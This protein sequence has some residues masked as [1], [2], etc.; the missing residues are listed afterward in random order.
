MHLNNQ[1]GL[2]KDASFD[3]GTPRSP[4]N[5]CWQDA[6][7]SPASRS[8]Q[9]ARFHM[10]AA[11]DPSGGSYRQGAVAEFAIFFVDQESRCISSHA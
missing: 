7:G 10:F 3:S 5:L 8:R 6:C 9:P 11:E 1:L 4:Q 2:K